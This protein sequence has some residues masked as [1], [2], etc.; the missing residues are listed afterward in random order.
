[1]KILHIIPDVAPAR[2]GSLSSVLGFVR[3]QV[4]LG[5]DVRIVTT[6][7]GKDYSRTKGLVLD[8][9]PSKLDAWRWSPG[10]VR[11]L[12]D[13]LRDRD[14]VHIHTIWDFPVLAGARA[15]RKAGKPY[16]IRPCGMLDE[17][18]LSQ[19]AWKKKPYM[20]LLL[21]KVFR[22]A[23]AFHFTSYV[24]KRGVQ[25]LGLNPI[26]FVVPLGIETSAWKKLP[27]GAAFRERFPELKGR[28]V[29]LFLGRLDS[30]KQPEVMIQAFRNVCGKEN[31]YVLVLAGPGTPVMFPA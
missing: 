9:F 25:S 19:K 27:S 15:C 13:L 1:M 12:P 7:Y 26:G 24:E 31:N 6:E 23:A 20:H 17:L 29:V 14:I 2:G 30:V 3:G 4:S 5:Y 28:T 8:K 11:A 10:L 22:L 16:I 21:A 18:C